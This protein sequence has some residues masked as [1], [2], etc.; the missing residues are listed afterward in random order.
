[1]TC[2]NPLHPGKSLH[3]VDALLALA[4]ALS[5]AACAAAPIEPGCGPREP[6]EEPGDPLPLLPIPFPD[7][8]SSSAVAD[9]TEVSGEGI[10]VKEL[11]RRVLEVL[12]KEG[13]RDTQSI[14]H[15]LGD[16]ITWTQT[17]EA[18]NRWKG[19][20]EIRKK[21]AGKLGVSISL[22]RAD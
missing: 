2:T 5:V 7:D 10:T 8:P 21:A 3:R 15:D 17:D 13:I 16:V 22:R 18:G 12:R 11:S 20:Y 6:A 9:S 4:A 19:R 14:R 1:M